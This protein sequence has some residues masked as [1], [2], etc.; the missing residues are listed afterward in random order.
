MVP[1]RSGELGG[2]VRAELML[3][4][5][6]GW[7]ERG[8]GS[9]MTRE[10]PELF[11]TSVS[12][13][14]SREEGTGAGGW[15]SWVCRAHWRQGCG[16]LPPPIEGTRLPLPLSPL[17]WLHLL[18][19]AVG[20]HCWSLCYG[21]ALGTWG[22]AQGARGPGKIT[23]QFSSGDRETPAS[24]PAPDAAFCGQQEAWS[25]TCL[26][27]QYSCQTLGPHRS[28]LPSLYTPAGLG[29]SL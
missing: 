4:G 15:G 29:A 5:K 7:L 11:S 8:Q 14:D 21:S 25:W 27:G 26:P 19:R 10:G 12:E 2:G 18:V 13:A 22:W 23:G 24:P 1:W 16:G 3:T 28:P 20:P 9:D 6:A 17:I